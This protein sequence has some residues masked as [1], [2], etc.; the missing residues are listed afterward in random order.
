VA[1]RCESYGRSASIWLAGVAGSNSAR[2]LDTCLLCCAGRGPCEGPI[3]RPEE[4]YRI[5]YG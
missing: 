2:D 1:T 5:W 3:A 4:F